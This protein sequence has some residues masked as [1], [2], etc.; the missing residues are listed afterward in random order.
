MF[1]LKTYID[2]DTRGAAGAGSGNVKQKK[3]LR[4][5]DRGDEACYNAVRGPKDQHH[6]GPDWRGCWLRS[7]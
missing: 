3:Y 6:L 7:S 1:G 2:V 5:P 4:V